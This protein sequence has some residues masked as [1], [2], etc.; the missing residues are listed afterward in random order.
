MKDRGRSAQGEVE[1][2]QV[3]GWIPRCVTRDTETV[4]YSG[5]VRHFSINYGPTNWSLISE[6]FW[7][8]VVSYAQYIMGTA[9]SW[10]KFIKNDFHQIS[11]SYSS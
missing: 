8:W 7:K 6:S 5:K 9:N 11:S 3:I 10:H 2:I 1:S 4:L